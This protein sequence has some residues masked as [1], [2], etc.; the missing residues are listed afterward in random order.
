[1]LFGI[2]KLFLATRTLCSLCANAAHQIV[3]KQTTAIGTCV[4]IEVLGSRRS[5]FM[6]SGH[7]LLSSYSLVDCI[8][9]EALRSTLPRL[10]AAELP[11]R[12][13]RQGIHYGVRG[14]CKAGVEA[15]RSR[16][17]VA[18]GETGIALPNVQAKWATTA[19]RQARAGENVP[20]TAG[21]A[22][23]ARRSGSG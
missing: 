14:F 10:V 21:R 13:P 20:R 16:A 3:L 11:R 4:W 15:L 18:S 23:V 5:I 19:G 17:E 9:C 2:W 22:K 7:V 12:S 6:N 8:S 1:M